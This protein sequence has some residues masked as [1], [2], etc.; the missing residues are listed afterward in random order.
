MPRIF[1]VVIGTEKLVDVVAVFDIVVDGRFSIRKRVLVFFADTDVPS[2]GITYCGVVN[3]CVTLVVCAL[4][5][6]GTRGWEMLIGIAK[7][8]K[9]E[10][11]AG[12]RLVLA[13]TMP[14]NCFILG[15]HLG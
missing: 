12:F 7:Y 5:V 8:F 10:T 1:V 9:N 11:S 15:V 4:V 6:F 13:N 2:G 3:V 14:T